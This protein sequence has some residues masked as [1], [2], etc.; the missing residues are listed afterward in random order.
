MPAG[1]A[2]IRHRARRTGDAE[3][4]TRGA[5]RAAGKTELV[6]DLVFNCTGGTPTPAGSPVPLY[7]LKLQAQSTDQTNVSTV[8]IT[9][10]QLA[11]DGSSEA[12]LL[13][14][15]PHSASNPNIPLLACGDS[16]APAAAGICTI[17]GSG[18]GVNT[19]NGTANRPNVFQGKQT[20][21]DTL[22]W[23]AIPFDPP[24]VNTTRVLR[25]TNVRMNGSQ[26]VP[27]PSV[28]T[29]IPTLTSPSG[30]I[31]LAGGN[32]NSTT[33]AIEVAFIQKSLLLSTNTPVSALPL[34]QC[35]ASNTF[36]TN[37]P[38]STPASYSFRI[39]IQE[40]IAQA[41]KQKNLATNGVNA[42]TY[43]VEGDTNQNVLRTYYDTESAFE[44]L[45]PAHDPMPN[46][47]ANIGLGPVSATAAFPSSLIKAG[48]ADSGT[49]H[50]QPH[51]HRPRRT[52]PAG[53]RVIEKWG[54]SR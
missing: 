4:F 8:N 49:R 7:T 18:T 27:L 10:R 41:F 44:N 37:N 9:S 16:T 30:A 34:Q 1:D 28:L 22:Q 52:P 38:A 31:S 43:P 19:Y 40:A 23:T 54:T 35:Q 48:V 24:G 50:Q 17:I 3:I 36:L 29:L 51:C 20:A 15:E 13:I 32:Q 33:G 53:R 6:G 11:P 2:G 47:P 42:T 46:P 12:I 14:D 39:R 26:T 5:V 21:A 25:I 45:G